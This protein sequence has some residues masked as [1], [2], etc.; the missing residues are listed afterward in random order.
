MEARVLAL[1]RL[2]LVC[3]F[4]AAGLPARAQDT[5]PSLAP[6]TLDQAVSSA[7]D[8]NS[9]IKNSRLEVEISK[10]RI[11][12]AK[13]HFLPVVKFTAAGL[14][15]ITP[16]NF[17]FDKGVFGTFESTGPIPSR[18]TNVATDQKPLLIINTAMVQPILQLGR[19]HLGYKQLELSRQIAQ[20]KLRAQRQDVANQI[21]HA[22][23]K[24]LELQDSM[25][26]I[27][28]TR[29]LYREIERLTGQYLRNKTVLPADAIEV[30]QQLANTDLEYLRLTNGMELQKE[31]LNRLQGR[32]LRNGFSL[33]GFGDMVPPELDLT[34]AQSRALSSRAELKQLTYQSKQIDLE[35]RIKKWQYLPDLNFI[36]DYLSVFGAEVLPRNIVF[37]GLI[38]NW[39]PIDWGRKHFEIAE[40]RKLLQQTT[41]SL[42]DAQSQILTEVS[43]V[44][45]KLQETKQAVKVAQIGRELA[46]ERLRV[47]ADK[48]KEKAALLKEVLQGQRDLTQANYQYTQAILALWTARGDFEKAMGED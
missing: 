43:A 35:R 27:D 3:V 22:Y 40:Q 42:R 5:P 46:L 24:A 44:H 18:R 1:L 10:D 29:T 36:I 23:Y 19:V 25:K 21:R 38:L 20:E 11:L 17:S 16:L 32:D 28:A 30:R 7:L 47:S 14:Q 4:F 39:E 6:V 34:T 45:R 13:T 12:A 41:N 48:Y 8:N 26:V 9:A 33:V 15:L 2:L 31:E 37:T